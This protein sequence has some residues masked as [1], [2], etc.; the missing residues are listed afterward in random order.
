M[1]SWVSNGFSMCLDHYGKMVR[2]MNER[3]FST[4][5]FAGDVQCLA[6]DNDDFLAVEKLLCDCT[7]QATK[8]VSL[9]VNNN[10]DGHVR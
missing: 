6:S 7:G 10:L 1:R 8:Q 2:G 4:E 9:A 5:E 3:T